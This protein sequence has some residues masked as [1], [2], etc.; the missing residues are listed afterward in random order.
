MCRRLRLTKVDFEIKYKLGR[1][2]QH[3]DA[4]SQLCAEAETV[5]HHEDDEIPKFQIDENVKEHPTNIVDENFIHLDCLSM[6]EV[7]ATKES[8]NLNDVPLTPI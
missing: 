1:A 6:D 3:A 5:K 7:Y 8:I 4:L 2:S